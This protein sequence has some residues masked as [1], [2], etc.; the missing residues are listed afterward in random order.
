MK[1]ILLHVDADQCFEA[2]LQ[3]ALDL[4]RNSGG[5]ITCLQSVS[6]EVFAPGDFYGSA[7]AAAMPRIKEAAEALRAKVEADLANENVF[8]E[9]RF[10][11]GMAERSLLEQSALND[12]IVVGPHDIGQEGGRAPSAMAGELAIKASAPVLVVPKHIESFDPNAPM[13]VAWNGSAESCVALRQGL[14]LLAG[15][16][17][18]YLACV[19]EEGKSERY[20]FPV[21]EAAKYL[22]RHGIA[23]EVVNIPRGEESIADALFTAALMRDCSVM[24]MGAYGH[25]RLAELLMGGVTRRVLSDPKLPVL[26]AH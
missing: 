4:A 5:H 26:L 8:W 11:Y 3:T 13:L 18:V 6:Y 2:R 12:V 19:V 7:M 1:S 14:P 16:R 15:A 20:E 10:I 23:S 21:S 24:V 25:S 9:W 17:K 22:D